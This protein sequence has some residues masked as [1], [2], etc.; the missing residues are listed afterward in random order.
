[1]LDPPPFFPKTAYAD[2]LY[3]GAVCMST[4]VLKPLTLISPDNGVQD[5]TSLTAD[6]TLLTLKNM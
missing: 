3:I 4:W 6:W 2:T 1:M 5:S